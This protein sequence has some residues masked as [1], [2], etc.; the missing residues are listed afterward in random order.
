MQS[1]GGEFPANMQDV[2][3]IEL[4]LR[5]ASLMQQPDAVPQLGAQLGDMMPLSTSIDEIITEAPMSST[6]D[7]G[8]E[9]HHTQSA[10][11]ESTSD[12]ATA[13]ESIGCDPTDLTSAENEAL[14]KR[15]LEIKEGMIDTISDA[16][17]QQDAHYQANECIVRDSH[18][19]S[20]PPMM[21]QPMPIITPIY[22]LWSE[23]MAQQLKPDAHFNNVMYAARTNGSNQMEAHQYWKDQMSKS[24]FWSIW[25]LDGMQYNQWGVCK[26]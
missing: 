12:Y 17:K 15:K 4:S 6:N 22:Q 13:D 16:L 11:D 19:I 14:A 21:N 10:N 23:P 25:R 3:T 24:R 8:Q 7:S 9:V 1:F 5:L 2:R 18:Q 26:W 20:Q